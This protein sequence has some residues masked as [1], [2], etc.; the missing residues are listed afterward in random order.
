MPRYIGRFSFS[1]FM[2]C[3]GVFLLA[4]SYMDSAE[5]IAAGSS[6]GPLFF[7]RVLLWIWVVL[8]A[9]MIIEAALLKNP[10]SPKVNRSGLI[11]ALAL[12]GAAY[13]LMP[14][15]GFLPTSMAFMLFYPAA[16]GYRKIKVLVPLSILFSVAVWY[17]FNDILLISLP[18]MPW[19]G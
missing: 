10:A 4:H 15:I 19:F 3:V 13:P 12:T 7:P 6:F 1:A 5:N 8:A 16:L 14:V 11:A 17:I 9:G 2:F 18:N